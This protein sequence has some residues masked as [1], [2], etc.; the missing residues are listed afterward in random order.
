MLTITHWR[1][2]DALCVCN[3]G[4]LVAAALGNTGL[5]GACLRSCPE[6][7]ILTLFQR[8]GGRRTGQTRL[9]HTWGGERRGVIL[10]SHLIDR[11]IQIISNQEWASFKMENQWPKNIILFKPQRSNIAVIV[12]RVSFGWFIRNPITRTKF[13]SGYTPVRIAVGSLTLPFHILLSR[14]NQ[15]MLQDG[16]C[17]VILFRHQN[18]IVMAFT[19]GC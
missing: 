6:T 4:W 19:S 13:T 14:S 16:L 5:L 12:G 7:S 2:H 11:I 8:A 10:K 18:N 1:I 3:W 9:R 17:W 15:K